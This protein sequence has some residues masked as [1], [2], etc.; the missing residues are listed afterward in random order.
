MIDGIGATIIMVF[1]LTDGIVIN[2]PVTAV[3]L[4]VSIPKTCG[5]V[6]KSIVTK[7]SDSNV[8]LSNS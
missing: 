5:N 8:G 1:G 6:T 7:R 2:I 3:E 4:T